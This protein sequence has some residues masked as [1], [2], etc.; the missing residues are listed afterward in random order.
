MSRNEN[1]TIKNRCSG[2]TEAS[3]SKRDVLQTQVLVHRQEEQPFYTHGFN[4]RALKRDPYSSLCTQDLNQLLF[5]DP[6]DMV[7]GV[8]AGMRFADLQTLLDETE[9]ELP[10]DTWYK[11]S[12]I[13]GIVASNTYGPRR[14][15]SGGIRD[16]VIGIEYINGNAEVVK[17]GGK[18]VKN[19]TGYDLGKMLVGS[20]GTLGIITAINFKV[21]PKAF[22][23]ITLDIQLDQHEW[24]GICLKILEKKLPIDSCQLTHTRNK[25][26][27]FKIGISGNRE[28]K[29]RLYQ[30]IESL[31][32]AHLSQI[33]KSSTESIGFIENF[34]SQHYQ[35][36][37]DLHLHV[38]LSTKN[39][40][41]SQTLQE[42][43][44]LSSDIILH[45]YGADIH[46]FWDKANEEEQRDFLQATT[47][48]F[49][50]NAFITLERCSPALRSSNHY[51]QSQPQ[52]F[53]AL[54]MLK[55]QLDPNRIFKSILFD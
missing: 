26:W 12:S 21:S 36:R 31:T 54:N 30:E 10:I 28:R 33:D 22:D 45:P 23:P 17:S 9:M 47:S 25:P 18:V 4:S 8:E 44:A 50:E 24:T 51:F 55:K 3:S 7:V 29:N 15:F 38:Q 48:I 42:L 16:T 37:P 46:L 11:N 5:Y 6:D 13:G 40:L 32:T 39:L 53:K 1:G 20:M 34:Q 52:Q 27:N 19:V 49:T 2:L 43:Q 41:S 35:T 14:M